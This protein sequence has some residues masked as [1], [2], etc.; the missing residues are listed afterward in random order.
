MKPALTHLVAALL[1][2]LLVFLLF[3]KRGHPR[4]SSEADSSARPSASQRPSGKLP[5]RASPRTAELLAAAG[6]VIELEKHQEILKDEALAL[7]N[8]VMD[9]YTQRQ[10]IHGEYEAVRWLRRQVGP[11]PENNE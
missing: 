6:T 10:L 4:S 3:A 2:G 5:L 8:S 7:P 1:S 11:P 9:S